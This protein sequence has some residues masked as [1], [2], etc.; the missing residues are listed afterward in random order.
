MIKLTHHKPIAELSK[1]IRKISVFE[2]KSKIKFEQKLTPS[3]FSYLSYNHLDIPI[4][5]FGKKIIHPKQ[6]LQIAGPKI[7]MDIYVQYNGRLQQILI[8]FTASG[9]YCLFHESPLKYTNSLSGLRK[10]SSHNEYFTF[11]K[12]LKSTDIVQKQIELIEDFLSDKR[13][14]A[15]PF[16][17]Y[18]EKS[19]KA[20]EEN[21]GNMPISK[22]AEK[23]DVS[24]RQ[25]ERKF[26]EVVGMNPKKYSQL[27]QLH[28][29][30][31]LMNTKNY[32]SL[33]D[34]AFSA[35]YYDLPHLS[36]KF[37]ELTGFT[38]VEFVNSD[39][40]LAL[41]FFKDLVEHN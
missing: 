33:Q 7:N 34:I 20:I 39:K 3:A 32:G 29:V 6:R 16:C 17:D 18:I 8:E 35:E 26:L 5:I 27:T 13:C 15:L 14:K 40:H 37:K 9:F 21:H 19:I 10:F 11:E 12:E 41:K 4:S 38:P 25:L 23:V 2:S 36:H 1:Y 31:N 22:I 30:I 24:E 28:Y